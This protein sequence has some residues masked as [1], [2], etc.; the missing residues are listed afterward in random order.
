MGMGHGECPWGRGKW[1]SG[2]CEG[3]VFFEGKEGTSS[4][5]AMRNQEKWFWQRARGRR[6]SS[7]KKFVELLLQT[8]EISGTTTYQQA[9]K[10]LSSDP[11]WGCC[12]PQTRKECF[13]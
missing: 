4:E 8:R 2:W 3:R 7:C 13:D 1:Q 9:E 10:M 11:A 6:G 12:D 5:V